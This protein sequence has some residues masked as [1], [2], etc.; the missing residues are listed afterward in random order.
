MRV[1]RYGAVSR[2]REARRQKGLLAPYTSATGNQKTVLAL[3]PPPRKLRIRSLGSRQ[4][5]R[6]H[7]P[8][9]TS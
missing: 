7:S 9:D 5:S 4:Y 6:M 8:L 1:D 2:L 3:T